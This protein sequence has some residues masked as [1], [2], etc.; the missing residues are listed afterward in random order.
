MES[1]EGRDGVSPQTPV[2]RI[3][4]GSAN[5]VFSCGDRE[6]IGERKRERT[7]ETGVR[8]NNTSVCLSINQSINPSILF[9]GLSHSPSI[10]LKEPTVETRGWATR[11]EKG[12]LGETLSVCRP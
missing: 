12:P 5:I 9:L 7:R 8:V 2:K 4:V 1:F 11:R 10:I 6:R 3:S